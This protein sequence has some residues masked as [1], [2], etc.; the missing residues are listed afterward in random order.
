[1]EYILTFKGKRKVRTG[2]KGWKVYYFRW[3]EKIYK[4]KGR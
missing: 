3:K 1:M 4:T 2:S